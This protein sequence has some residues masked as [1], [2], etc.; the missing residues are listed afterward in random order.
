MRKAATFI[1]RFRFRTPLARGVPS[2]TTWGGYNSTFMCYG[3][4]SR[5]LT[6]AFVARVVRLS[7][8]NLDRNDIASPQGLS[9]R[10]CREGDVDSARGLIYG[11]RNPP[12]RE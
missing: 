10:L 6:V 5:K 3:P 1:E 2:Q 12:I 8:W 4:E 9:F 7:Y 11:R